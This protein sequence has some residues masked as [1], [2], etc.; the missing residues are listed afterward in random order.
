LN[1]IYWNYKNIKGRNDSQAIYYTDSTNEFLKL[2]SEI[3]NGKSISNFT[4]NEINQALESLRTSYFNQKDN[5]R[6]LLISSL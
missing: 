1:W 3:D 5:L 2:I 4:D 6:D